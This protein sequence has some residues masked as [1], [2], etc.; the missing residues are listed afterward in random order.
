M[1][2]YPHSQ[3]Q[4][5]VSLS[6]IDILK[7]SRNSPHYMK[8]TPFRQSWET[9]KKYDIGCVFTERFTVIEVR[10][11]TTVYLNRVNG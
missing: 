3:K 11:Q 2:R 10:D 8:M 7:G 5:V 1:E 6:S 9:E 4:A